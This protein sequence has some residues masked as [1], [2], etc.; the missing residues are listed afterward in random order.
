M[1]GHSKRAYTTYAEWHPPL[2][3]LRLRTG[4][5]GREHRLRSDD[6]VHG[7]QSFSPRPRAV[8]LSVRSDANMD[9]RQLVFSAEY[10]AGGL[11]LTAEHIRVRTET[12]TALSNT[13]FPAPPPCPRSSIRPRRTA[14]SPTA[15]TSTRR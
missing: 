12:V 13:P 5:A 3:G 6:D 10:A 4:A 9:V 15:S 1:K 8:A 2:A 7:L 14:S 11:R